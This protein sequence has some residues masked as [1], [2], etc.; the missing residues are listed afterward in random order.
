MVSGV[1]AA[2][3][4][5][6]LMTSYYNSVMESAG[7]Q[8]TEMNQVYEY[9]YEMIVDSRNT[10]FW[11]AVYENAREEAQKQGAVLKL[12]GTTWGQDYDKADFMD[13]SI[14]SQVDGIILEYNGEEDLEEKINEAVEKGIP[15]VTIV[16]D[17]PKASV[18]AL[19]ES[20]I[21]S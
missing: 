3:V 11:K 2:G 10:A 7:I 9:Q 5:V 21:T 6:F 15:V 19:W 4:M 20:V 14:A 18:S 13:M 16:N 12:H 1:A 8:A 17:A